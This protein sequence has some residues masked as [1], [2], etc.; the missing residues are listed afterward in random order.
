[1]TAWYAD[2]NDCDYDSSCGTPD[3]YFIIQIDWD[4]DEIFDYT[5]NQFDD[6]GTYW[7]NVR[8][9]YDP[10]GL[11]G[12]AVDVHESRTE[13]CYVVGVMDYD[14]DNWFDDDDVLDYRP[15]QY[16][17]TYFTVNLST[18]LDATETH[19]A[20]DSGEGYQCSITYRIFAT[21]EE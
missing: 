18:Y 14:G 5:Y 15:D 2:A 19:S 1:M 20:I 12:V 10:N 21:G 4:C 6:D 17:W 9:L 13:F 11:V 8:S 16:S 3:P 7:S